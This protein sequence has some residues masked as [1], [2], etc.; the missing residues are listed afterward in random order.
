M[1]TS[2]AIHS[3]RWKVEHLAGRSLHS[4]QG[5]EVVFQKKGGLSDSA[6]VLEPLMCVL[7]RARGP[8]HARELAT[9]AQRGQ[10]ASTLP[11]TQAAEADR[12]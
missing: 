3:K 12:R 11:K 4:Q 8:L 10:L 1:R 5:T 9:A 7:A 6:G 2:R